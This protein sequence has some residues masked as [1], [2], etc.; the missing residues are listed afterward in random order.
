MLNPIIS[1]NSIWKSHSLYLLG[2]FFLSK[3]EN[4]KAKEFFEKILTLDN[5]NTK[6]KARPITD[7]NKVLN[8]DCPND[9]DLFILSCIVLK[10]I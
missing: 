9:F 1:S 5:S 2:E 7:F 6:I 8:K 3:N 4:Q 10:Y